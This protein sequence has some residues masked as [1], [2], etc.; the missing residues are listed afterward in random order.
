MNLNDVP[1]LNRFPVRI[2]IAVTEDTK[3]KLLVIKKDLKKDTS[4]LVRMLIEEF[5][6]DNEVTS[7]I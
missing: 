2:T 6:K 4:E 7:V 3:Q 5:F 1:N